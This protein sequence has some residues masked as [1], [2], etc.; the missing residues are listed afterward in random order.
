ML[1]SLL[2]SQIDSILKGNLLRLLFHVVS[3]RC[4]KK[5]VAFDFSIFVLGK[6]SILKIDTQ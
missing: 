3:Q 1:L 4:L 5:C 6:K 2:M